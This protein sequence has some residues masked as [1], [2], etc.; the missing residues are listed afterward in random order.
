MNAPIKNLGCI[1]TEFRNEARP[2][3]I[4]LWDPDHPREIDYPTFHASCDAVARG[5]LRYGL[6][7]GERMG[8]LCSNRVEFLEIF[9]GAMRAG[10]IPVPIGILQPKA[11]VEWVV[12]DAQLRLVFCDGALKGNLPADVP[13]IDIDENDRRTYESFKDPGP[14]DP[15]VPG[16]DDVAFQPYTSGSTGRPKGVLLS[17]RAHS[18]VAETISRDRG[19]C[20][21]DR[22]I[23]AAPLYHKHAMNSI[24]CV[25][26][27]GSTVI[28]MRKF[29]A[30]R[31]I[32]A[33]TRHR[34][35]VLSGVPTIFAMIL[36][37]RD[38]LQG[39]DYDFV[40]LA[41]MGGAPA[42]D[43]L[44]DEV[45]RVFP[46]AEII[47]IFGTTETSAALFGPHPE[48]K[49]RPRHSVGWPVAGN[50]FRLVGGDGNFGTLYVKGPG[51]MNGYYNNPEEMARRMKDGW[52]DTGD[53]LR[54]DAEGWYYFVG[55]ADDMFVSSG[56][57]IYPGE[58]E[59]MLERHPDIDQAIVVP[60][61][62]EIKHR[63]PYAFIV[64]RAG[65]SLTAED[66]KAY[67]LENAPPYQHPRRV[68][69]VDALPLNGVGK[70]DRKAL[71]TRARELAEQTKKVDA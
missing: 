68:I 46:R 60:V 13:H 26:V 43:V 53:V 37:Q 57:N 42:S 45:A 12:R 33:I 14:F 1:G 59:L 32:E 5:L 56:H 9:F 10:I 3:V 54:R 2:A 16:Y 19:F 15:Y 39:Q 7:P 29:D 66:V 21:T 58:V 67:A 22:M 71:E 49:P 24:K 11:T 55:R 70:I 35:T 31:Y 63:I 4:D 51:M 44:I 17:H 69:F 47:T 61:P 6:H 8:I 64:K 48:G 40:R 50:S 27:G 36:Q 30:R 28:L 34:V 20:P 18:W 65:S 62:D 41:T 23:V 25:L 38:L 52:F